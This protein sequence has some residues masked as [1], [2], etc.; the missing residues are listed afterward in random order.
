M[1]HKIV[2]LPDIPCC[3]I[4]LIS[5]FLFAIKQRRPLNNNNKLVAIL[6]K[7]FTIYTYIMSSLRAKHNSHFHNVSVAS[8]L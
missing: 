8:V 1:Y 7:A 4:F 3:V 6:L 2:Q 5:S